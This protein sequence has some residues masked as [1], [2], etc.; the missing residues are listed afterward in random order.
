MEC[1]NRGKLSKNT[2]KGLAS[3]SD[4]C[5]P[6]EEFSGQ[7]DDSG[8]EDRLRQ[9]EGEVEAGPHHLADVLPPLPLLLLHVGA[10]V[11]PVVVGVHRAAHD[12]IVQPGVGLQLLLAHQ[13]VCQLGFLLTYISRKPRETT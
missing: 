6:T 13:L 4:L 2:S 8:V 7:L 9:G 3:F 11:V 1:V 12:V 10:E 5:S